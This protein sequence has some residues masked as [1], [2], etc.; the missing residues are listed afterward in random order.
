MSACLAIIV[1]NPEDWEDFLDSQDSLP[2]VLTCDPSLSQNPKFDGGANAT[3][4]EVY[5]KSDDGSPPDGP[6]SITILI[7]TFDDD[8]TGHRET[9]HYVGKVYSGESF[10]YDPKKYPIRTKLY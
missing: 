8:G 6:T 1:I 3:L 9:L 4:G 2:A 7:D 5:L 10:F